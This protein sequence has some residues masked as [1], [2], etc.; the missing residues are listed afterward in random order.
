[1]ETQDLVA[2]VSDL[3]AVISSVSTYPQPYHLPP[4]Y[5]RPLPE[6]QAMVCKG[7]CQVRGFY[8]PPKGVYLNETLDIEHDVVARSVLLHE[9]VHY[10][11]ELSGRFNSLPDKCDRWWSREKE[12]YD[13]QNAYLRSSGSP[14]RFALDS[15]PGMCHDR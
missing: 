8:L 12:A 2:L 15:L 9:L 7:P 13:I 1:V 14:R 10:V 11:Q 6:L 3:F 5:R 4:V